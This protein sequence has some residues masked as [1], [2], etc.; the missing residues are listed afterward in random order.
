VRGKKNGGERGIR[1][2]GTPFGIHSLSRRAPS[3]YSAISPLISF[4]SFFAKTQFFSI[5]DRES[6]FFWI[7]YYLRGKKKY[8]ILIQ[9]VSS[10]KNF[11]AT[12]IRKRRE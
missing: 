4:S 10:R 11:K 1:T 7:P 5:V 2:L 8:V 6:P 12:D 3:T 9:P